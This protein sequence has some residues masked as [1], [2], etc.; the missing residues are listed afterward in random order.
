MAELRNTEQLFEENEKNGTFNHPWAADNR[1]WQQ[2][3]FWSASQ[4]Q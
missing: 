3:C 1:V 4:K 2:S